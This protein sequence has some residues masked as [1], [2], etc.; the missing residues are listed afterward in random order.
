M[1]FKNKK[2]ELLDLKNGFARGNTNVP[3]ELEKIMLVEAEEII[4]NQYD[5][6]AGSK[7]IAL[8]INTKRK[9]TLLE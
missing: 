3:T 6:L 2:G 7:E 4:R 9:K 5:D 8:L 1:L